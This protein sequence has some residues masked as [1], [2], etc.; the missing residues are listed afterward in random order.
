M[1]HINVELKTIN[2]IFPTVAEVIVNGEL[3]AY[4]CE[5]KGENREENPQ[6]VVL[7]SGENLGDF[8]CIECAVKAI[9]KHHCGDDGIYISGDNPL[10]QLGAF[11]ILL[12]ALAERHAEK[13][14][15]EAG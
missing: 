9:A 2:T 13:S 5:N 10:A 8:H 4:L 3:S 6:S 15:H 14:P 1:E 7:T 11:G 12:A